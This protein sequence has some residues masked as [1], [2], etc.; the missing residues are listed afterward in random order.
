MAEW[1]SLTRALA[2]GPFSQARYH[3]THLGAKIQHEVS[4][5]RITL[6]SEQT[7]LISRR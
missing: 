4:L 3:E 2:G 6:M 7:G 1:K 5:A